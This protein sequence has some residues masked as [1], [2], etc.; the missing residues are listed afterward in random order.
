MALG[1]EIPLLAVPAKS[2]EAIRK[3]IVV[4]FITQSSLLNSQESRL[5]AYSSMRLAYAQR[6]GFEGGGQFII[7]AWLSFVLSVAGR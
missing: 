7:G 2:R 1:F 6:L 5:D 4:N 3:T